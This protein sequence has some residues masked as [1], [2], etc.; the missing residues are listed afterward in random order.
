MRYYCQ[1]HKEPVLVEI[2]QICPDCKKMPNWLEAKKKIK[3][4][5]YWKQVGTRAVNL[6]KNQLKLEL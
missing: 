2:N 3:S 1:N 4:S 5:D 6:T